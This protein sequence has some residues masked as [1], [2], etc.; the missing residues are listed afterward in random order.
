MW[1]VAVLVRRR[2]P[3]WRVETLFGDNNGGGGACAATAAALRQRRDR[4]I[5]VYADDDDD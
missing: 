2:R 3:R 5:G 1:R 4:D